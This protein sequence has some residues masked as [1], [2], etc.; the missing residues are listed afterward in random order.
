MNMLFNAECKR[1][2]TV[3]SVKSF[4]FF[5][6]SVVT[7][8]MLTVNI[9]A[10]CNV[11]VVYVIIAIECVCGWWEEMQNFNENFMRLSMRIIFQPIQ[12]KVISDID[13]NCTIQTNNISS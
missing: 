1:E 6:T 5:C 12:R 4:Y 9:V 13:N 10:N 11:A 8:K 3:D 7:C 2:M